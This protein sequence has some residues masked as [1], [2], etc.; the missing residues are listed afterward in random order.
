MPLDCCP[1]CVYFLLV[2][3]ID[4]ELHPGAESIA[5]PIE[6]ILSKELRH[7][8]VVATLRCACRI[9]GPS[10]ASQL[11]SSSCAAHTNRRSGAMG[12]D[13]SAATFTDDT[14]RV[15]QAIGMGG[16]SGSSHSGGAPC[17]MP[18]RRDGESGLRSNNSS[19][20][21]SDHDH[22]WLP[23]GF[24][25]QRTHVARKFSSSMSTGDSDTVKPNATEAAVPA[26]IDRAS[27]VVSIQQAK[28]DV[29]DS[30]ARS[31]FTGL[32]GGTSNQ[33]GSQSVW[34]TIN[35][36]SAP[37]GHRRS[38]LNRQSAGVEPAVAEAPAAVLGT[39][40]GSDDNSEAYDDF[41][42]GRDS[43]MSPFLLPPGSQQAGGGGACVTGFSGHSGPSGVSERWPQ[44]EV[45]IR[46]QTWLVMEYC[47]R[48][49]LQVG[50]QEGGAC[51]LSWSCGHMLLPQGVLNL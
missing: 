18:N 3:I 22:D 10:G 32:S 25:T 49:C 40:E 39:P 8:H 35:L 7:P 37:T 12:T 11:P 6:A 17:V 34:T 29:T 21:I 20:V 23:C 16:C 9:I 33:T 45:L 28:G 15:F 47:D 43:N 5:P 19:G 26:G 51:S 4:E 36:G 50:A 1:P 14:A 2:Q 13:G 24:N 48:G 38:S 30:T 44:D 46:H 31:L 42:A 41:D 27:Q